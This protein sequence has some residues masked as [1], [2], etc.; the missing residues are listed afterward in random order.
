[1]SQPTQGGEY[2]QGKGEDG[3]LCGGS[4]R[5]HRHFRDKLAV[6]CRLL[7]GD[8]FLVKTIP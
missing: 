7:Q 4:V 8:D 5:E 6:S 1:M 2:K 3:A